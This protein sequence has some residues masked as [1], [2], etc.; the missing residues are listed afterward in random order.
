MSGERPAVEVRVLI[1]SYHCRDAVLTFGY[2]PSDPCAVTI[3]VP[4]GAAA[5]PAGCR[6]EVSRDLLAD[7]LKQPSGDGDFVVGPAD[8][9]D[10]VELRFID[11]ADRGAW[12]GTARRDRIQY[13]LR[14]TYGLV[15][16][17][18]EVTEPDLDQLIDQINRWEATR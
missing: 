3:D 5:D 18:E 7:G 15:P 9:P 4:P 12:V 16:P 1:R 14:R 11:A 8:E 17:G 10:R 2:D 13:F 6:W